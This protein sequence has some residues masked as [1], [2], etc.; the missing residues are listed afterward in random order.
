M[1][2]SEQWRL[3]FVLAGGLA[4][5]AALVGL[6]PGYFLGDGSVQAVLVGGLIGLLIGVGMVSFQ[7]SWGVGL[8]S[9][10]IREAPFLVVLLTKSVAWL[11]IIFVGLSVPPVVFGGVSIGDLMAPSFLVSIGISFAVAAI[12]NFGFQVNQLMGRGVLL[13]LIAGRYH[14]PREEDRVFLFIDLRGSTAIAEQLG[15]IRYHRLLRRFIADIT[16][17]VIRNGGEIHRYVGDQIILTWRSE[18]GIKN[19]ACIRAYFGMVDE[20]EQAKDHYLREYGLVPSFWAGL[21]RGTV[22]A[23]EI[24]SAKHEI[25]Y[26]GD[27]MNVGARIE[28][29]CRTFDRACVASRELIDAVTLPDGV[30]AESLGKTDLRGVGTAVELYALARDP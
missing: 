22:V 30:R 14:R 15:N 16:A 11:A 8:I 3:V 23:G 6:V 4:P 25:V 21:H 19:A 2:R 5:V 24:G 20:I 27:T 29:S 7:V 1:T 26:L 17:P 18:R 28:Q 9:R 12:I 10:R 13:G